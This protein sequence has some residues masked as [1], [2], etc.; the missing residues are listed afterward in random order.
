MLRSCCH[1]RIN[2][3][4]N[5]L[6]ESSQIIQWNMVSASCSSKS[7]PI[8]FLHF[9]WFPWQF[10]T[11]WHNVN[12]PFFDLLVFLPV[13]SK[14][15]KN[16]HYRFYALLKCS[17]CSRSSINICLKT[18]LCSRSKQHN[19]GCQLNRCAVLPMIPIC[20][21]Q[22]NLWGNILYISLRII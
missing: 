3:Y 9:P 12:L 8:V 17:A 11:T 22:L 6:L 1:S 13:E 21:L 19:D 16:W 7:T 18:K 14:F 20:C 10:L 5:V 2:S 4:F 15:P